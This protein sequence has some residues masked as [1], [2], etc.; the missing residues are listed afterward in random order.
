MRVLRYVMPRPPM[1]VRMFTH[2]G[3]LF[4]MRIVIAEENT[5]AEIVDTPFLSVHI[6]KF[7]GLTTVLTAA[8]GWMKG[9]KMAEYIVRESGYPGTIKQ[10]IVC[11]LVRCK[12]CKHR[13][14]KRYCLTWGQPYLCND[15]CFC[16]YGER[17]E[18]EKST[19]R[20][21]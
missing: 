21:D 19:K 1:S 15:E 6:L 12:D 7:V 3:K 4:M 16:S 20:T 14:K 5:F 10:E 9:E 17:R 18:D 2:I 13:E 11:E 8:H